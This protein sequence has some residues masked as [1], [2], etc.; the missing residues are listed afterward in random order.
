MAVP[1]YMASLSL[2]H[3]LSKR[4]AQNVGPQ[5][6]RMMNLQAWLRGSSLAAIMH[7]LVN[8]TML[9]S[10]ALGPQTWWCCPNQLTCHRTKTAAG[11]LLACV[12]MHE[13][14]HSPCS[15]TNRSEQEWQ[16]AGERLEQEHVLST[17]KNMSDTDNTCPTARPFSSWSL[18]HSSVRWE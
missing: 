3:Q 11:H 12:I 4:D 15:L 8:S 9:N 17:G 7:C 18:R 14:I 16:W 6:G 10:P 2:K 1:V 13:L 5:T